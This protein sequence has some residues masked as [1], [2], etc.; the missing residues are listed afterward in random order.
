MGAGRLSRRYCCA[1]WLKINRGINHVLPPGQLSPGVDVPYSNYLIGNPE[2]IFV[3]ANGPVFM[4][5]YSGG[6]M[7]GTER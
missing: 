2:N 3:A 7:T 4:V 1:L 6:K 5:L